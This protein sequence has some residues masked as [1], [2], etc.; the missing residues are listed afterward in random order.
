MLFK[1]FTDKILDSE[2]TSVDIDLATLM[3]CSTQ[4]IAMCYEV[5]DSTYIC[6]F[7]D[8]KQYTYFVRLQNNQ[9]C[10]V[11][12]IVDERVEDNEY[13]C[14]ESIVIILDDTD[15]FNSVYLY[16]NSLIVSV[17]S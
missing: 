7:D 9:K 1:H 3:R 2:F 5:V 10:I 8:Y 16:K 11:H 14:V 4:E 12:Q 6:E 17:L 13:Q 15:Y